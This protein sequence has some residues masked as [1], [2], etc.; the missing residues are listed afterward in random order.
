M[1]DLSALKQ[2][3]EPLTKIGRDEATFEIGGMEITILPLL[4]LDE[5]KV[6][7]YSASVLTDIQA[8][9]GLAEDDQ[10]SRAAA[11]DYFDRFRIEIISY[12][13]VQVDSLDLRG[14][15]TIP[16]GEVL[17]NG[18][19][20]QI[21]RPLAMREIVEGWSRAMLTVCFARYGDL[22]QRIADQAD[23]IAKSSLPDIEAEIGRV[24]SRLARLKA[25]LESRAAG[26]PSITSKQ[27]TSLIRAG[28][29][30]ETQAEMAAEAAVEAAAMRRV[31]ATKNQ[32]SPTPPPA[33]EQPP[34]RKSVI[35]P[36]APP[37]TAEPVYQSSKSVTEPS[38]SEFQSSFGDGDDPNAL[39]VEEQR[40]MAA[41][42]IA[43]SVREEVEK[44]EQEPGDA[45]R[46]A[47]PAGEIDGIEAYRLP[48]ENMSPRGRGPKK[49]P[50]EAGP[51]EKR[52]TE[53]PNFKPPQ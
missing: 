3:L 23:K 38:V 16:T 9:E 29:L 31:G 30:M 4:H 53:N 28:D 44:A 20:V 39:A 7:R 17:D 6:Q 2:A 24:E 8:Q 5:V 49:E 45:L 41:R 25:D 21:P 18:V 40:I 10:M 12:S 46:N 19:A 42:A 1:L 34:Q 43:A 48:P 15:E 27:I 32:K 35:P 52:G 14:V 37:P 22:V 50:Q 13:I 33:D 51:P 36:T 47:Q 11:L 26:D